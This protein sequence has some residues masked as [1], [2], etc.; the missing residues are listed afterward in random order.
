MLFLCTVSSEEED[1][2]LFSDD[3]AERVSDSE[4]AGEEQVSYIANNRIW[5]SVWVCWVQSFADPV[6]HEKSRRFIVSWISHSLVIDSLSLFQ[7][8]TTALLRLIG[9]SRRPPKR[10]DPVSELLDVGEYRESSVVFVSS[11]SDSDDE[12]SVS[13]PPSPPRPTLRYATHTHTHSLYLA[14]CVLMQSILWLWSM[15]HGQSTHL[16]QSELIQLISEWV[17]HCCYSQLSPWLNWG[18]LRI[19]CSLRNIVL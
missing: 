12:V 8:S 4:S 13:V 17:S 5:L 14:N 9:R 15:L 3:L 6:A 16:I 11:P 10:G 1:D 19:N 7:P 2:D 18:L